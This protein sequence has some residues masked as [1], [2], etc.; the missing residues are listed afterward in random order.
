MVQIGQQI[1]EGL[2]AAHS[3]GLIHRDIKPGN[4]LIEAGLFQ[5]VKI[6]DFGLARTVDDAS[7]TQSG[8]V[9]GTPMFMAPEQAQGDTLDHRADLFSFGSVLYTIC[10]GRPPFRANGTLA[11][12][13]RVV[14]DTPRPIPE[15]IPEVPQ[16]LCD[17]IARL[18]AKK[19][20]DRIGT[21]REVADLLAHG[22]LAAMQHPGNVPS[23]PERAPGAEDR[24]LCEV[25]APAEKLEI[26]KAAPAIRRLRFR[27]RRWA[28]AAAVCLILA[29]GLGFAETNGVT[30]L[31]GT[32]IRLVSPE[33]TLVVEVD[34]PGISIKIDGADLVITGAG[35]KEIRLKPGSYTVE[36]RKDGKLVRQELVTVTRNGRQVVRVSH[37]AGPPGAK[38]ATRSAEVSAWE[39]VVTVLSAAEQVK[40]VGARLKE[41]NPEFDGDFVPTFEYGDLRGLQFNADDVRDISPVRVLTKLRSLNCSGKGDRISPLTDLS[42]LAGMPLTSLTVG[43]GQLVDLSPLKGMP[44][45]R[46]ATYATLVDDLSPLAGM[47]LRHLVCVEV[48]SVSDISALKGMPLQTLDLSGT[49]VEDLTALEGMK[50][51][52]L[53]LSHTKVV[54]LKV[55]AG[56]RLE[57]LDI[58]G[59]KVS[60]LSQLKG[61]KLTA[62]NVAGTPVSDLTPLKGMKL[63]WMK[64]S[65]TNVS[66]L[67]PLNG[68]PLKELNCAGSKVSDASLARVKDCKDLVVLILDHTQVSDAGLAHLKDFKNLKRLSLVN[69]RV[70]GLSALKGMSL[71]EIRVTPKNINKQ[72]LDILRGM[73]SLKTIGSDI[74]YP[75]AWP[76]AEFWARYEKGEFKK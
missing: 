15:I 5:R 71:E 29:G 38:I 59:T 12:L 49:K 40:A 35:A 62:L 19:P 42:P 25:D 52:K 16:W 20:E 13:K 7:V 36:A 3:M 21:A 22:G 43:K 6:T 76:P 54:D 18:H 31:R 46:F 61:L 72:G 69:T 39:R 53:Y 60:D 14:E 45:I 65:G 56:M 70:S 66:D 17:I 41:L 37:E 11:V 67:S 10:S 68:T 30:D 44:L 33:G 55:L 58:S 48:G 23:V 8:Y 9:A 51:E 27:T 28:A 74:H 75:L 57:D 50:L 34:D 63:T 2:A 73:K 24:K 32:I 64:C 4:I 1:A 47:R 26:L